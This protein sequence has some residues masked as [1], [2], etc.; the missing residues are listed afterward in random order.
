MP[1]NNTV[2]SKRDMTMERMKA[3]YPERNFDDDEAFFGQINDDYD[4]YDKR[5]AESQS[6]EESFSNMFT[7]NPKSARLMMEWKNGND[8]VVALIR[9]YGKEDILSAI[10]DPEKL[11]AIET[12]NKEFAERVAKNDEYDAQYEKNL[13][14]SLQAIEA[15]AA[16][17]G[18]SDDDI[19]KAAT[20]LSKLCGDFILGKI[21]PE[22]IEM[23]L[24][25]QNYDSDI[26]Q[27]QMEG[28]V[29]GRNAK[30]EEKLRKGKQGDGT[31]ALNG[32]NGQ[33]VGSRPKRDLGA[34]DRYDS[35]RRSI[36]ERGGEK[37]IQR[38]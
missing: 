30:I 15:W 6:R 26:E 7:S 11:E 4:D 24:K 16:E 32:K 20:A 14:A 12:A 8:P 10:E 21:A 31:V 38:R 37:R 2:K 36:F 5:L 34:L 22:S 3:K 35:G 27:A 29:A 9:I 33:G 23:M 1:D 28:E 19:D 25:A 18:V 13:P 17:N